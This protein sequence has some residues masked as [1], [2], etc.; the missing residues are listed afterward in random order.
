[1]KKIIAFVLVL[2]IGF[3]AGN[4]V[5]GHTTETTTITQALTFSGETANE[6]MVEVNSKEFEDE[7]LKPVMVADLG[8]ESW[9]ALTYCRQY[10]AARTEKFNRTEENVIFVLGRDTDLVI[11]YSYEGDMLVRGPVDFLANQL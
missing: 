9:D 2:A 11:E 10:A 1:M 6:F 4:F 5:A 7:I 8:E 3:V